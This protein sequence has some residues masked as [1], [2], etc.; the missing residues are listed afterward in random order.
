MDA[1][2]AQVAILDRLPRPHIMDIPRHHQPLH[3]LDIH[4][5]PDHGHLPH[6]HTALFL[7][8]GLFHTPQAALRRLMDRHQLPYPPPLLDSR[9]ILAHRCIPLA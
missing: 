5:R 1:R 9:I 6:P 2:T 3:T 8:Q 7:L 4:L